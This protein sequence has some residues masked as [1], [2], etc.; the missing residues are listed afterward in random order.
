MSPLLDHAQQLD[1]RE[2]RRAAQRQ[3]AGCV[4]ADP[5]I[6]AVGQLVLFVEFH[7]RRVAG[8]AVG[9]EAFVDHVRLDQRHV[10]RDLAHLLDAQQRVLEVVEDAEKE[11]QVEA[12]VRLGGELVDVHH[13][14]VDFGAE[15]VAGE[16]EGR[17]LNVVDGGDVGAASLHLEREPAVP[18]ADIEHPLAREVVGDGEALQPLFLLLEAL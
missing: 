1:P 15:P 5:V 18:G 17:L 6:E 12:S 4:R 13:A 7:H 9:R 8:L 3:Q 16:I 14:V 2:S 10:A 11:D